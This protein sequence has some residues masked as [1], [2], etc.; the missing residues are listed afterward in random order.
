MTPA[1]A[2]PTQMLRFRVIAY[3]PQTKQDTDVG[4]IEAESWE[5]AHRQVA[6]ACNYPRRMIP[7]SAE[8]TSAT[9]HQP[10]TTTP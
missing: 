7:V 10:N 6:A 8:E 4:M 9:N 1:S 5:A 3:D 2:E